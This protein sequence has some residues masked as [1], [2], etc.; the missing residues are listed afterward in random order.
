MTEKRTRSCRYLASRIRTHACTEKRCSLHTFSWLQILHCPPDSV[1]FF[2]VAGSARTY[3]PGNG[4]D[5]ARNSSGLH[6]SHIDSSSSG[7]HRMGDPSG[8]GGAIL[9]LRTPCCSCLRREGSCC[10]SLCR[11]YCSSRRMDADGDFERL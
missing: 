2:S 8:L 6:L 11:R 9:T 5:R 4:T 3:T 10:H 1:S 7:R